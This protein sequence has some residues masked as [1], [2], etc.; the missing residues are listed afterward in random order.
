MVATGSLMSL[1]PELE[2]SSFPHNPSHTDCQGQPSLDGLEA[3]LAATPHNPLDRIYFPQ[4]GDSRVQ[5]RLRAGQGRYE[6]LV[7]DG[8]AGK[9][10]GP[11]HL[12]WLDQTI[13]LHHN[14]LTGKSGRKVV[15]AFGALLLLNSLAGLA[16][17]LMAKPKLRHL[18][19][20]PTHWNPRTVSYQWH[21]SVGL[22][23]TVFLLVE[24]GTGFSLA[25]PV[26]EG[27]RPPKGNRVT[28]PLLPLNRYLIAARQS[29]PEGHLRELRVPENG[30]AISVEFW[31][32]TIAAG[33]A[34]PRG[35]Q[36]I[37]LSRG[38]ASV[39]HV[40]AKP[41]MT[42]VAWIHYSEWGGTIARYAAAALGLLPL[43]LFVSGCAIWWL[44]SKAARKRHAEKR[45]PP[46]PETPIAPRN[47]TAYE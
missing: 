12:E 34:A 42:G 38:D 37:L 44:Q 21:R 29:R 10:I 41:L 46:L 22:V 15:G 23:A 1:R 26:Q 35:D 32:P 9:L 7:F 25:F 13:D 33:F 3:A 36:Q 19:P 8:C 18:S 17:W 16:L 24:A 39:I 28:T 40:S 47:V 2:R 27:T 14:L 20:R 6:H 4:N 5:L 30:A 31:L 11:A 43:C 45:I